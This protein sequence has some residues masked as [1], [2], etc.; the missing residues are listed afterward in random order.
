M[1]NFFIFT[2]RNCWVDE[3]SDTVQ[4]SPVLDEAA[5]LVHYTL[6]KHC[7][8]WGHCTSAVRDNLHFV[9][10][11]HQALGTPCPLEASAEGAWMDMAPGPE[12]EVQ[13]Q[14]TSWELVNPGA[15]ERAPLYHQEVPFPAAVAAAVGV[16]EDEEEAQRC[17]NRQNTVGHLD[18][19][20]IPAG[21]C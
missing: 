15:L 12:E 1:S 9:V 11:L 20:D 8:P 3:N 10:G 18:N 4:D 5:C 14:D 21:C 7:W 16:A 13:L 2:H 17:S 6:E 19:Q